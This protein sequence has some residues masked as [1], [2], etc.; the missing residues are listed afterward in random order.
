MVVL[1]LHQRRVHLL[2]IAKDSPP[3]QSVRAA[4]VL[5]SAG[6]AVNIGTALL[7]FKVKQGLGSFGVAERDL[8]E[9]SLDDQLLILGLLLGRLNS[10][11]DLLLHPLHVVFGPSVVSPH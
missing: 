7:A 2:Y 8:A 6:G 11:L 1:E 10:A 3:V 4:K 9:A 5:V